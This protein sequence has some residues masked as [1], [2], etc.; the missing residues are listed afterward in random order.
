MEILQKYLKNLY[1]KF[2]NIFKRI[3]CKE[4]VYPLLERELEIL[5]SSILKDFIKDYKNKKITNKNVVKKHKEEKLE[6]VPLIFT[7]TNFNLIKGFKKKIIKGEIIFEDSLR[8]KF[9]KFL[10]R[11]KNSEKL[12]NYFLDIKNE[13]K[14]IEFFVKKKIEFKKNNNLLFCKFFQIQVIEKKIK[15][16]CLLINYSVNMKNYNFLIFSTHRILKKC[17]KTFY[18]LKKFSDFEEKLNEM[19]EGFYKSL[20]EMYFFTDFEDFKDKKKLY[21]VQVF[22]F[23]LKKKQCK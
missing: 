2:G 6:N 15:K 9:I 14:N 22:K 12:V 17:L 19:N 11:Y 4:N 20:V 5:D 16:L 3:F 1:K 8:E 13:K 7:K 23:D 18:K 10:E 21:K